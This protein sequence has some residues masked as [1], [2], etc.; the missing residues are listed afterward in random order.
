MAE[1]K[2]VIMYLAGAWPGEFKEAQVFAYKETLIDYDPAKLMQALKELIKASKFRP[3]I[4]EILDMLDR[5]NVRDTA[6]TTQE[7]YWLA[8]LLFNAALRGDA[9]PEAPFEMRGANRYFTVD[10]NNFEPC[11]LECCHDDV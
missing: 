4:A 11:L 3:T 10:E 8:M 9:H 1:I 2:D 7:E 5:L 6:L